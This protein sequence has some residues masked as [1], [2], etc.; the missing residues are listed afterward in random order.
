MW[1]LLSCY[2][3]VFFKEC[4]FAI[5]YNYSLRDKLAMNVVDSASTRWTGTAELQTLNRNDSLEYLDR[6]VKTSPQWS[7]L[8]V[9]GGKSVGKST[10]IIKK[11]KEWRDDGHLVVDVNL[12]GQSMSPDNLLNYFVEEYVEGCEK[13]NKIAGFSNILK[14]KITKTNRISKRVNFVW[15]IVTGA[16]KVLPFSTQLFTDDSK[17]KIDSAQLGAVL[18]NALVDS[19]KNEELSG[20]FKDIFVA[21][22][23]A[24]EEE[25][26]KGNRPIL[27]IREAQQ[28][29]DNT[30][31]EG[32]MEV[33]KS[34]FKCFEQYKLGEKRLAV[35]MESSEDL[36]G[37][38]SGYVSL[39]PESFEELLVKQWSK[40]EGYEELV[41]RLQVFTSDEYAKLWDAVGGHA[42]QLFNLYED[43]RIGLTLDE[44]IDKRNHIGINRLNS[45]IAAPAGCDYEDLI[46]NNVRKNDALDIVIQRRRDF[47]KLLRDS[48][49][50]M[51]NEEVP[52][53]YYH[54]VQ[55]LC[56]K[57]V[58]WKDLNVITPLHKVYE[59]AIIV[60]T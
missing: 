28:L 17:K 40:E 58:L 51:S 29:I 52:R 34:L 47:L 30:V 7:A 16:L 4:H 2:L 19:L 41:N 11:I 18:V 43:L 14:N 23:N 46:Q 32:T 39:S 36:W 21:F 48:G 57:N 54:T 15:T 37:K 31:S 22:I 59:N 8:I 56:K 50:H 25:A 6:Q 55:Y 53:D 27:I 12:H 26:V 13:V 33:A 5:A 49:F 38:L 1:F 60:C 3:I 24:L 45:M 20:K 9:Y 10:M 44:A 42:G 35:I